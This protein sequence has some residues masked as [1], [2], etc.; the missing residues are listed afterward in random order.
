MKSLKRISLTRISRRSAVVG[1]VVG[2]AASLVTRGAA[3]AQEPIDEPLL[4]ETLKILRPI[5]NWFHIEGRTENN[6]E[7]V[8]PIPAG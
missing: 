4:A 6:D 1:A 7:P 3:W 5:H 2:V 8:N